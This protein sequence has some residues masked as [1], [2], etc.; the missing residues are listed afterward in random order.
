MRI[1]DL[2]YS[3]FETEPCSFLEKTRSC[4]L[5]ALKSLFTIQLM[6]MVAEVMCIDFRCLNAVVFVVLVECRR[7]L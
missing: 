4:I 3:L 2:T 7:I 6:N 5:K 1:H